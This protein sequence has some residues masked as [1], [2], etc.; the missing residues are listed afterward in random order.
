MLS[1]ARSRSCAT[2]HR[3]GRHARPRAR[4]ACPAAPSHRGR[5]RS[6]CT[7]GRPSP[8][9]APARRTAPGESCR[10]GHPI[11][12]GSTIRLRGHGATSAGRAARAASTI[13]CASSTIRSRCACTAK[14]LGVDLVDVLGARRPSG[15]PAGGGRDLHAADRRVVA[16]RLGDD[17]RHRFA[18]Q[19]GAVHLVRRERGQPP[20][21]LGGRRRLDA[22]VRRLAEFARQLGVD[23]ARDR[24]PRAP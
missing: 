16:R 19:L 3:R 18:G 2:V 13:A 1:V 11:L 24:D 17:A 21:L 15:E 23:L 5:E 4:S 20:L 14:A 22:I 9:T 6:S 8:R 12:H 7:R 10:L